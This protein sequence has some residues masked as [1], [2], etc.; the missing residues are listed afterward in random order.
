MSSVTESSV[1]RCLLRARSEEKTGEERVCFTRRKGCHLARS[2]LLGKSVSTLPEEYSGSFFCSALFSVDFKLS[3][4]SRHPL[5]NLPNR[6]PST[7]PGSS[8]ENLALF[9]EFLAC[10]KQPTWAAQYHCIFK[11][12]SWF[13][14]FNARHCIFS[15][16]L[17]SA[18]I[19]LYLTLGWT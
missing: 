10:L 13:L 4:S 8:P 1:G 2:Q 17:Y 6:S 7:G 9:V 5:G 18:E 3:K 14:F 11:Y 12:P 16:I 15:F 19:L